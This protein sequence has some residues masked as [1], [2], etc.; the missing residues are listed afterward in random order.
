MVPTDGNTTPSSTASRRPTM[1]QC[2]DRKPTTFFFN[3]GKEEEE[4]GGGDPLASPA[5]V[6]GVGVG[7]AAALGGIEKVGG[8]SQ[9]KGGEEVRNDPHRI[10][11]LSLDLDLDLDLLLHKDSR[12]HSHSHSHSLSIP[13]F[14]PPPLSTTDCVEPVLDQYGDSWFGYWGYLDCFQ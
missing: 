7:V 4:D 12:V 3:K 8:S 6:T 2:L 14:L 1:N 13:S 10:L 5:A 11:S 9:G